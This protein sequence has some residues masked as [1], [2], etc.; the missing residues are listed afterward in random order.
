MYA[1]EN[2]RTYTFYPQATPLFAAVFDPPWSDDT[3][4]AGT[5]IGWVRN[6]YDDGT[7]SSDV[8]TPVIVPFDGLLRLP[9]EGNWW[10]LSLK[11]IYVYATIKAA[12]AAATELAEARTAFYE[13]RE[14]A[15]SP[16]EQ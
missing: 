6:L 13:A 4:T 8:T 12:K 15:S 10:D 3:A 7:E 9:D 1:N 5:V 16:A 11:D 14:D 2:F